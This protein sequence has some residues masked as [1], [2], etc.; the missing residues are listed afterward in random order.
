MNKIANK[1][2]ILRFEMQKPAPY[3]AGQ[4]VLAELLRCRADNPESIYLRENSAW[5]RISHDSM[6]LSLRG[7]ALG[8]IVAIS[9]ENQCITCHISKHHMGSSHVA[10]TYLFS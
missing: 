6:S 2:R 5:L 1:P 8:D 10:K 4:S 7:N 9:E 3:L